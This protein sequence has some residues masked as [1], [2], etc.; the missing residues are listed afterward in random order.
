MEWR[1]SALIVF[2][3]FL[4]R[5]NPSWYYS[6]DLESNFDECSPE[7]CLLLL[8]L[9]NNEKTS[10]SRGYL[11]LIPALCRYLDRKYKMDLGI[12]RETDKSCAYGGREICDMSCSPSEYTNC[13]MDPPAEYLVRKGKY[14][15]EKEINELIDSIEVD[16]IEALRGNDG[17]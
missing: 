15:S 16:G 4:N 9:L 10:S 5:D 12:S 13:N 7:D 8:K 6:W 14:I 11:S 1:N 3:I 2:R 17:V